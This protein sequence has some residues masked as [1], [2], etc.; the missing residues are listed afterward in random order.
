MS[1]RILGVTDSTGCS[2]EHWEL[3][4]WVTVGFGFCLDCQNEVHLACLFNLMITRVE[5]TLARME[6]VLQE[7]IQ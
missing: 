1:K 5:K 4:P 2:H 3:Q 6:K 7:R